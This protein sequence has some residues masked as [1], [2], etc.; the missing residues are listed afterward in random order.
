[1]KDIDL[2]HY[3]KIFITAK[4]SLLT[5]I[6]SYINIKNAYTRGAELELNYVPT[7]GLSISTGYQYLQ[8][9]DKDELKRIKNQQETLPPYQHFSRTVI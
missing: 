7:K 2:I 8:T 1:M 6:F 5:L 4:Y 3:S 9:G